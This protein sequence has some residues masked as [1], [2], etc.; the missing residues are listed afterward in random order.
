MGVAVCSTGLAT[1]VLLTDCIMMGEWV[2][3][4]LAGQGNDDPVDRCVDDDS[5]EGLGEGAAAGP[6]M[7]LVTGR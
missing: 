5:T 3:A 2:V 1:C 4:C 7:G 6:G